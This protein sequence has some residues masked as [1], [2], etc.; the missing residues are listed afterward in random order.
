M[1]E[2][3]RTI[4][5]RMSLR[6]YADRPVSAAHGETIVAQAM[7]A[8]TAGNMMLYSIL[9]VTK[10]DVKARLAETCGHSFVADAPL[11]LLFLADMQRW[12][13][14]FDAFDAA[15]HCERTGRTVRSPG[16]GKL[17]MAFSDAL[18]AAQT[19]VIAAESLGIGSCYVGDIVGHADEHRVLFDLPLWA[20]PVAL[21]CYGH[22][23]EDL[24]RRRSDRFEDRFVHFRDAY[25]RLSPEELDE[26]LR[27]IERRFA[28]V[29]EERGLHLAQLTYDGFMDGRAA[30]EME[31]GA[32]RLIEPWCHAEALRQAEDGRHD[33]P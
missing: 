12:V 24:P 2:T 27:P 14:Y 5:Q 20:V 21:V 29:L 1:N 22:Y 32:R 31:R 7:R 18:L 17:L 25:R 3:L 19:S 10:A 30:Q 8:P 13:D 4:D 9:E 6:R 26:M 16:P 15:G 28:P 11:V 33:S 23:P